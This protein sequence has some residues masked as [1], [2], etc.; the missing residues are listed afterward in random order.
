M[1]RTPVS[2]SGECKKNGIPISGVLLSP[3]EKFFSYSLI[4]NA[5]SAAT[6]ISVA[7]PGFVRGI[8]VFII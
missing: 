5:A 1:R 8:S 6:S 7:L 3:A 2:D 4:N